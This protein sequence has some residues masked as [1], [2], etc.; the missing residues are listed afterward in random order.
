MSFYRNFNKGVF[1][2]AM[3]RRKN[4]K[5]IFFRRVL[6]LVVVMLSIT[7]VVKSVGFLVGYFRNNNAVEIDNVINEKVVKKLSKVKD[8][9][10]AEDS[11][12]PDKPE[13][14]PQK[15]LPEDSK[16]P[17]SRQI[18]PEKSKEEPKE[19]PKEN[20]KGE[21]SDNN[22]SN[23][24]KPKESNTPPR[25]SQ[26]SYDGVFSDT[27]FIGDSITEGLPAYELISDSRV[28]SQKGFT[29]PKAK[30]EIG[31]VIQCKPERIFILLGLN[32]MLYGISSEKY[33]SNYKELVQTLKS[34]L[35]DAKIYLQ[36][37]FPVSERVEK[38]KPLIAN[39]RIDEFN[40]ALREMAEEQGVNYVDVS[41]LFKNVNGRLD[42]DFS[43]DGIHLKYKAY[44]LWLDFL[45]CNVK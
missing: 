9:I 36:S 11:K 32:D 44:G 40:N 23:D 41:S 22:V 28:V 8:S 37:V 5:I 6:F 31:R 7:A 27:V 1:Y 15:P 18:P 19:K 30:A 16:N 39:P 26:A 25:I 2:T 21:T 13:V 10:D 12:E 34:N 17:N 20:P 42:E 45:V 43:S 38:N 33:A 3:R 14:K 35:P 4:R 29:V 24:E